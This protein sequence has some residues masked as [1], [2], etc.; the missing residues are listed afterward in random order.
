V[1][2]RREIPLTAGYRGDLSEHAEIMFSGCTVSHN[3]IYSA[4][5]LKECHGERHSERI[6]HSAMILRSFAVSRS[7]TGSIT[8]FSSLCISLSIL[9]CLDDRFVKIF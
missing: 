2:S 5:V 3:T 7:L 4:H 1:N 6:R 8:P 9:G